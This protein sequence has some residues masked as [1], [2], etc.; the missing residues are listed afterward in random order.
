MGISVVS[1]II[2]DFL[3]EHRV[4]FAGQELFAQ[5]ILNIVGAVCIVIM[6]LYVMIV[7]YQKPDKKEE[8]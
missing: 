4:K 6:I 5:Q 3:Q 8:A 2:L 1:G 7:V